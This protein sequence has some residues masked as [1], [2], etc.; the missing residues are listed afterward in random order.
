MLKAVQVWTYYNRVV[1]KI[2]KWSRFQLPTYVSIFSEWHPYYLY[3]L[4]SPFRLKFFKSCLCSKIII[5]KYYE[6]NIKKVIFVSRNM[7]FQMIFINFNIIFN[8]CDKVFNFTP[9]DNST[10]E[11]IQ[12]VTKGATNNSPSKLKTKLQC[13]I[14]HAQKIVWCC[15]LKFVHRKM[16]NIHIYILIYIWYRYTLNLLAS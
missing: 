5:Q 13:R 8:K 9:H 15:N 16:L 6:C 14:F 1:I 12:M 4:A 7:Y 3:L 10:K 11:H 2:L